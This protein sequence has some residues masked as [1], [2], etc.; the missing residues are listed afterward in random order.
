M[1]STC[2]DIGA[3]K[4]LG[5]FAGECGCRGIFRTHYRVRQN[6]VP[7]YIKKKF[8]IN[9]L[10]F[11]VEAIID[12][13]VLHA[14][15]HCCESTWAFSCD[16]FERTLAWRRRKTKRRACVSS[17]DTV[18][19]PWKLSQSS[20]SY[21]AQ[22]G[23]C[24]DRKTLGVIPPSLQLQNT[25]STGKKK[26]GRRDLKYK[27]TEPHLCRTTCKVISG[28]GRDERE[29]KKL[30]NEAS[31]SRVESA[32]TLGTSCP[33]SRS[34]DQNIPLALRPGTRPTCVYVF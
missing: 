34:H 27:L 20:L 7:I 13:K 2:S 4:L 5:R 11:V 23:S 31:T 32:G 28:E 18:R 17:F 1:I 6:E 21:A 26:R 15:Q 29:W 8:S 24:R 3:A 14:A 33:L 22:N 9:Y 12:S 30:T 25:N 16:S 19:A 10:L